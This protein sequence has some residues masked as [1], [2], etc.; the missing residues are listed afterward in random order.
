MATAVP[1]W[2]V[3]DLTDYRALVRA[4]LAHVVPVERAAR[5]DLADPALRGDAPAPAPRRAPRVPRR[6]VRAEDRPPEEA[7]LAA[8]RPR[9]GRRRGS[10]PS[11]SAARSSASG[12]PSERAARTRAAPSS[13]S[14]SSPAAEAGLRRE[15]GGRRERA[16]GPGRVLHVVLQRLARQP[17]PLQRSEARGGRLHAATRDGPGERRAVLRRVSRRDADLDRPRPARLVRVG[18][19]A[20]AR[21]LRRRGRRARALERVDRRDD[22]RR[23][24]PRRARA[25]PDLRA[26]GRRTRA[27]DARVAG[28]IGI[29]WAPS[30]LPADLQ[31]PPDRRELERPGGAG[32]GDP[33]RARDAP[34]RTIPG[35]PSSPATATSGRLSLA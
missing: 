27:D 31:R 8:A 24:A 1:A 35:S 30:L 14:C 28:R 16:R 3:D 9:R 32:R 7:Q 6:P 18:G 26:A 17:R 25:R 20:H 13:R 4:R 19:R 2:E 10:R 15:R 33:A 5:P 34:S 23:R 21:A 12:A 22:R 11:T 29:D